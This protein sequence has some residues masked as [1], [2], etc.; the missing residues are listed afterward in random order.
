[1]QSGYVQFALMVVFFGVIAAIPIGWF[2]L[3]IKS[4]GTGDYHQP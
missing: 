2:L 1:M 4:Y 3:G